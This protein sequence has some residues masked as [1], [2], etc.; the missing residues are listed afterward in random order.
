MYLQVSKKQKKLIVGI[1]EATEEQQ[2]P[3]IHI[4]IH[5]PSYY[6]ASAIKLQL[7]LLI[8]RK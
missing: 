4:H 6:L 2:D 8:A 3:W 7:F 5:S 1:L